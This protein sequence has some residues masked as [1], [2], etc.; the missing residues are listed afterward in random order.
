MHAMKREREMWILLEKEGKKEF[1]TSLSPLGRTTPTPNRA[2]LETVRRLFND[3]NDKLVKFLVKQAI[4]I[5]E[6]LMW[7]LCHASS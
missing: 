5:Y 7:Y 2:Y 1:Q 3:N 4:K 6:H